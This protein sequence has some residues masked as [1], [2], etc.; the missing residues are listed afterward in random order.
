[1]SSALQ[2]A[3]GVAGAERVVGIRKLGAG[4]QYEVKWAGHAET[5]WEAAWRVRKQIPAMVQAFEQQQQQ[6]QQPAQGATDDGE[7]MLVE[8]VVA[9]PAP[10]QPGAPQQ[11]SGM[12]L[13]QVQ[14]LEQLVRDQAQRLRIQEEQHQAAL[15]QLQASPVPSPQLLS[16]LQQQH[17][18]AAAAAAPAAAEPASRFARKEPRAQ[19]LCEYDGASGAKLDTWLDELALA[20]MLYELNAR[21]AL[22]FAVSRL[23]GAALQWWL[24]LGSSTQSVISSPEALTAALRVRFQPVTAARTAREQLDK[25]AQGSR[26][27]NEY[28]SDFQRLRTQLPGMAEEDALYAFERG[29]RRDLA[30]ELRKQGVATVQDAIALVAR[31]GG[32]LQAG[33]GVSAQQSR[34]IHQMDVGD[35]NDAS[36]RIDRLEAALNALAAG[37]HG[38]GSNAGMSAKTQTQR[39]YQQ[40]GARGGGRGGGRGASRGGRFGGRG[41][42]FASFTIPGVPAAI[43]EQRRAAGQCFRCGSGD[44]RS[45]ECPSA[46]SASQ[47]SF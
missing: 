33:A 32:L 13:Q 18:L 7:P 5:T 34:S 28:I 42:A 46:P 41:G 44:H 29:L 23:R 11:Q 20:R 30:V 10:L 14:A 31:I 24:A 1:M 40:D 6:Q 25:L 38:A 3:A 45:M 19:D 2:P 12:N 37:A 39:G 15:Q 47:P 17:S 21:E 35:G 8:A 22:R 26:G 16:P 9:A 36:G 27:V 43:V 4:H